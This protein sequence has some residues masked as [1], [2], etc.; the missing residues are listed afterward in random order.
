MVRIITDSAAD[1][2]PFELEK[3]NIACVPLKVMIAD[4]E[5]EENVNLGKAQFYELLAS[6]GAT[7]KT[8]QPS[9][10]HL[11]DLFAAAKAAG[12]EAVYI[13][14]SSGISGTYQTAC[15][16]REDAEYEGCYVVDSLNATAGERMLVEYAVRLRDEGKNAK[17]IVAALE[18][19]RSKVVLA[20]CI[21]TL[22][23]LYRGGRISQTVYKLGTMAQVKPII[24]FS[25][26]GTIEVPAKAMGMRKG[27]D[28]LC[29]R[30]ET[31]KPDNNHKIYAIYTGERS[32]GEALAQRM[33]AHGCEIPDEQ[34]I[35]VGAVI[36]SHIGPG[37]C[38]IIYIAE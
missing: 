34:I 3:L 16:T 24:R 4:A 5:Y 9:P 25:P 15:M 13:S 1:F 19:I 26:E 32:V 14:I 20:A 12:D 6:T 30:L 29:K 17:E 38:G 36:G 18:Q 2:E 27:L 23:Y 35:P 8:S 7:P 31:Q 11:A 10:Q 21:D 33:A 37:G 28:Q 22:E